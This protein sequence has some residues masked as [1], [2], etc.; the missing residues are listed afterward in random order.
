MLQNILSFYLQGLLLASLLIISA[1]LVWFVLR[2]TKGVDKTLQERQ[3]FLFDLLMIDVMT[4]PI[5][6]FG[7]V[8]I[9]LMLKA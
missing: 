4:I 3:D 1:S 7:I 8:G 9:L 5:V 6:A 2:M